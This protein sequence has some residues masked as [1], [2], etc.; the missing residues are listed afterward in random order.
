MKNIK[1]FE[2]MFS[3]P[4]GSA[5]SVKDM[6]HSPQ[7]AEKHLGKNGELKIKLKEFLYEI[8]DKLSDDQIWNVACILADHNE[9]LKKLLSM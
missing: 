9:E 4:D 1:K 7:S 3:N 5:I 2:M 6:K 8:D